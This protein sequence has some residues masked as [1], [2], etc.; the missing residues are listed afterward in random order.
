MEPLSILASG[1]VTG[2]GLNASAT[3]AAIR[4]GLNRFVETRFMD[5]GG[6]WILGSPVPLDEPWRG[7][8]KL[9]R[10]VVPVI[11]ECLAF[12]RDRDAS[13]E[14]IPLLLSVAEEH[15][16]GR[17][18]GLDDRLLDEMQTEF[19]ARFHAKSAVIPRGR[20]GG[21][22]AVRLARTLIYQEHLP[23]CLIA[24][25]D[26][27]LVTPTLVAF[28]ERERLLTSKN[29]DGFIPGE[30]GTAVLLGPAGSASGP[31]M[32]CLGIGFGKEEATVDSGEPLRANGLVKA[33]H[34]ALSESGRTMDDMDYRITDLSGEQYGFKEA[35][36]AISRTVRKLKSDFDIWH[37]A[38]CVGEIGAAIV[39][40]VLGIALAAARKGYAPG[41]GIL[42]HFGNDD[43]ERAAIILHHSGDGGA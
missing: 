3:C 35:S 30:A 7:R 38:D 27:L 11:Q 36:L 15:R 42:C 14:S 20:V 26:S 24:G 37:P 6:E 41:K 4:C 12:A 17:L 31:E 21:V 16:P 8:A 40:C 34:D 25:V 28:E 29:S 32:L 43:G 2:V 5:K 22:V 23:L 39:P 9:V 10:L 18:A 33:L 1:M 19:Q 13:L